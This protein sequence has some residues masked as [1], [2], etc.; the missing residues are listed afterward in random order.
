MKEFTVKGH[1]GKDCHRYV[2]DDVAE[3]KA[4][5]LL[6]HGMAEHG[7]RYDRLGRFLN[8]NG[9]LLVCHDLRGHGKTNPQTLGYDDGD[10]W[11]NN[12]NDQLLFQKEWKERTGLPLFVMGHSYGSFLTQELIKRN[13]VADGFVL[14]GSNLQKGAA[15]TAGSF[16]ANRLV[17]K[18]GKKV[19]AQKLFDL[20][21]T[22]WQKKCKE[23]ENWLTRDMAEYQK[24]EDD[25]CC[26]F[27]CSTNFYQ[28]FFNG[29]KKLYNKKELENIP[30]DLPIYLFAGTSDPV[31]NYGKGVKKLHRMYQ[32]LGFKNASL[33][34]YDD[35][36]HEMVN[37]VNYEEVYGDLVNHLNEMLV[38]TD[39]R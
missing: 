37:D 22:A 18:Q 23:G 7:A 29:L 17:K 33:K 35:G 36:R 31:G 30:K 28:T 16:V 24:Y 39:K 2:W 32:N 27:V 6:V 25:S 5:V 13:V 10:M 9:F 15:V 34:L 4:V 12:L 38:L 14:S 26:G 19:P 21:F 11:E 8:E 1:L 20:T 3:P